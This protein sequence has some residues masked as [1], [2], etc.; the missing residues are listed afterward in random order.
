M[1]QS[2]KCSK[3]QDL[4]DWW[5]NLQDG[6]SSPSCPT[7]PSAAGSRPSDVGRFFHS[8][9]TLQ[10]RRLENNKG[11]KGVC[12]FY[13]NVF[14]LLQTKP[15]YKNNDKVGVLPEKGKTKKACRLLIK[16]FCIRI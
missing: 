2:T 1:P 3:I 15:L 11:Y 14:K 9:P 4:Q 13:F 6:S 10:P 7:R 12:S 16:M 8:L 5:I